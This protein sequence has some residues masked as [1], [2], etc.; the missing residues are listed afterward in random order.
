MTT[1]NQTTTDRL[2]SDFRGYHP[3]GSLIRLSDPTDA[4]EYR[5]AIIISDVNRPALETEHTIVCLSSQDHYAADVTQLPFD[6]LTS[7]RLR[8]TAYIMPWAIYTIHPDIVAERK[9]TLNET[10]MNAVADAIDGMLRP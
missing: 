4:H 8:K 10:G 6:G 3:Q 9:G 1:P 5:Y 7:G 2:V